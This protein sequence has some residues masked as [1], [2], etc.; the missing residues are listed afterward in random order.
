MVSSSRITVVF[1]TIG[2]NVKVAKA[3]ITCLVMI[4]GW[5]MGLGIDLIAPIALLSHFLD[6]A[7][8]HLTAITG[9]HRLDGL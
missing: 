7:L 6:C 9:Y 2:T 1:C 5:G 3:G 8:V 4:L